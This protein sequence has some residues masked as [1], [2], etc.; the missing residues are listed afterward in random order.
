ME[1]LRVAKLL[2]TALAAA[3]GAAVA[4]FLGAGGTL[5]GAALVSVLVAAAEAVY[6]HS[7]A[8]AHRLARRTLVRR[9]GDQAGANDEGT[10]QAR[11]RPVRW[12]R[13]A[14]AAVLACGVAVGAI[15]AVEAVAGQPLA[16]LVGGRPRP[17]ASTSLGVVVARAERPA[18]PAT[19]APATSTTPASGL[20][21]TTTAPVGVP[22]TTAPAVTAPSTTAAT[23]TPSTQAPTTLG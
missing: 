21:P 9:M 15:T 14:A 7:F 10:G 19:R 20:A 23:T 22:A 18:P 3:S 5:L 8:S 17:G 16:S 11:P 2:A 6:A 4:S 1:K 12:Q 13:V